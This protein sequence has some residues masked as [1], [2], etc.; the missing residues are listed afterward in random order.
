MISEVSS[1]TKKLA[2]KKEFVDKMVDLNRFG[3][4]YYKLKERY[5]AE[6]NTGLVCASLCLDDHNCMGFNF[7][8]A[9]LS[10]MGLC[11]R[12]P[13]YED[14][15]IAKLMVAKKGVAYYGK[16]GCFSSWTLTYLFCHIYVQNVI[17]EHMTF[18]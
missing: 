18:L 1:V 2:F 12:V 13:I 7:D 11:Q 15:D 3:D 17:F 4:G 8:A 10:V 9:N 16:G 14:A 6:K 5:P